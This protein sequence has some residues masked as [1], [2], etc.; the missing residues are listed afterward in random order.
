MRMCGKILKRELRKEA[1]T[2]MTTTREY[3]NYLLD[4]EVHS[5]ESDESSIDSASV[6][7]VKADDKPDDKEIHSEEIKPSEHIVEKKAA[8]PFG[9]LF[10]V[11][12]CF[13]MICIMISDCFKF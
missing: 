9:N 12:F 13:Y 2:N 5:A 7:C 3:I 6:N 4:E 1:K 11:L 8:T 10:A